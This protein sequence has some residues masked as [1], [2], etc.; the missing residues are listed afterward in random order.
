MVGRV[1]W[2]PAVFKGDLGVSASDEY[3]K[4]GPYQL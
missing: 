2:D 4:V 1:P 3:Y